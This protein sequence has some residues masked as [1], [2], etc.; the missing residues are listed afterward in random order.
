MARHMALGM[1][2]VQPTPVVLLLVPESTARADGRFDLIGALGLSAV[3]ASIPPRRVINRLQVRSTNRAS[4][5]FTFSIFTM[6]LIVPQLM[7]LP[8]ATGFGMGEPLLAVDLIMM[9]RGL[10]VMAV[11]AASAALSRAKAPQ[12]T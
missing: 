11:A 6:K 3:L 1:P 12:S 9:P 7:Q 2:D 4:V 10:V 8:M 5:T